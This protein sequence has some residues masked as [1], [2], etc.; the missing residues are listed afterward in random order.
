[1]KPSLGSRLELVVMHNCNC[2][3]EHAVQH[4]ANFQCHVRVLRVLDKINS[5]TPVPTLRT[6]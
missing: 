3:S 1:M 5:R 6:M 4:V 2:I